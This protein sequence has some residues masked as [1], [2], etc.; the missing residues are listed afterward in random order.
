MHSEYEVITAMIIFFSVICFYWY[1]EL[2]RVF[3]RSIAH[4]IM[5]LSSIGTLISSEDCKNNENMRWHTLKT[6]NI[7]SQHVISNVQDSIFNDPL[8]V[9]KKR[10]IFLPL[11][12]VFYW[13]LTVLSPSIHNHKH[14]ALKSQAMQIRGAFTPRLSKNIFYS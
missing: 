12:Q 6:N 10:L 3:S 9:R 2:V 1:N 11:R 8:K 4:F 7:N 13:D 5:C 14:H